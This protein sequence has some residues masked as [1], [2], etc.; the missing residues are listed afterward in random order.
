MGADLLPKLISKPAALPK[1]L[2]EFFQHA[3]DD[4]V[5]TDALGFSPFPQFDLCFVADMKQHRIRQ[6]QALDLTIGRGYVERL[7]ANSHIEKYM[8]KNHVELL[9]EFNKLLGE[10][11][12]EMSRTIPDPIRKPPKEARSVAKSDAAVA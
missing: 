9:N 7:L 8:A 10:K 3:H 11:A 12:E 2:E 5:H 6:P 1:L 4:G